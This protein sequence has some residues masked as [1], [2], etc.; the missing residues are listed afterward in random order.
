MGRQGIERT[1]G[2]GWMVEPY[3][4]RGSGGQKGG[5]AGSLKGI[6]CVSFGSWMVRY[7]W[8]GEDVI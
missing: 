5:A 3:V 7:S 8:F 4:N 6:V 2:A 1:L